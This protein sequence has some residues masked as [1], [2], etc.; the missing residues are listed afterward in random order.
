MNQLISVVIT[1]Y[2]REMPI[3]RRAI[4]SVIKQSYR[5]IELI[6]VNDYPP[7]KDQIDGIVAQYQKSISI[8]VIHNKKN[9]GACFSRNIGM[10]KANGGFVAYLDDDD[11]WDERKLEKQ[12]A[13]MNSDIALVYC[14]GLNIYPDGSQSPML[15]VKDCTS[16]PLKDMLSGNCMGGCSFPLIR[17]D[18]LDNLGGFDIQ[19]KSSQDYDLWLRIVSEYKIAFINEQLV[20]YYIMSDSITSNLERRLQGYYAVLKKHKRQFKE[21]P[22]SAVVFY[23]NMVGACIAQ[24][25]YSNAVKAFI[26]SFSFFPSNLSIAKNW[27]KILGKKLMKKSNI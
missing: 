5:N 8:L 4:E 17:K 21:Y 9:S 20:R 2:K 18:V 6:I 10:R 24:K 22:A 12:F 11:E 13:A 14:T 7:Y 25:S 26:N 3:L 16:Q 27:M 23:N 1:T 15:F 19:L